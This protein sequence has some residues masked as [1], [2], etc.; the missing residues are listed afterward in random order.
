[1]RNI[2]YVFSD[3]FT[4]LIIMNSLRTCCLQQ[5]HNFNICI[6]KYNTIITV[7]SLLLSGKYKYICNE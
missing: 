2:K 7:E 6:M 3:L 1:M 4:T 5:V